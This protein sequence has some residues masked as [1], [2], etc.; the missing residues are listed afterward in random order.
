MIP[1]LRWLTAMA[2]SVPSLAAAQVV[3]PSDTLPFRHGQ[4]AAQ[5]GGG[6]NFASLG[7]LR[8]TTPSRAWLI[9]VR[10]DGHHSHITTHL[11][12]TLLL[13]D[14]TST[15]GL[16]AR[17]GRRFYQS[18]GKSVAVFQSV[19]LLGGYAHYCSGQTGASVALPLGFCNNGWNAGVFGELGGDYFISPRFSVGGI[20]G[21]TFSYER[22][23]GHD[24]A[25]GRTVE[26]GYGGSF[27]GLA[28]VAAIYF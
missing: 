25:G 13:N 24:T 23:T 15:A 9:D 7:L 12:D 8:F 5:F 17:A 18:R 6:L 1:L 3:A 2:V 21:V 26:W 14:F 28:F 11:R 20:A 22:T 4:W 19:G 16:N 10:F 27:E